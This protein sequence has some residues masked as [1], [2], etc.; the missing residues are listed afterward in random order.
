MLNVEV[1]FPWVNSL[2]W[3]LYEKKAETMHLTTQVR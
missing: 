1:L 3:K 2:I